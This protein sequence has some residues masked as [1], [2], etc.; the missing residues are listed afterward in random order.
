MYIFAADPPRVTSHP[1]DLKN[2]VPG[3]TVT[4]TAEAT[5]TEPLS[6]H[7]WHCKLAGE[8]GGSREWQPC[9]AEWCNGA[10]LTIPSVQKSDEGHY[11]CLISNCAGSQS[12]EP[13]YLSVGKNITKL[14]YVN[15]II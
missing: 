12:S 4:F 2:V 6:Y 5:G 9:R 8:G 3:N 10:T 13:A 7:W 15:I 14:Q 1:H 11:C